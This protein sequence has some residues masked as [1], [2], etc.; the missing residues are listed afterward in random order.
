MAAYQKSVG[1]KQKCGAAA[2]IHL[3]SYI[4]DVQYKNVMRKIFVGGLNIGVSCKC[5]P[6]GREC[7]PG[8]W[9]VTFIIGRGEGAVFNLVNLGGILYSEQTDD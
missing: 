8:G 1:T 5:I 6:Q 2:G 3:S 4:E 9:E 7:T